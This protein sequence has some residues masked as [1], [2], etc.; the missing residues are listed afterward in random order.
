MPSDSG[1]TYDVIVELENG[2]VFAIETGLSKEEAEK[3]KATAMQLF[4]EVGVV[5]QPAPKDVKD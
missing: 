4:P 5:E 2:D 1:P 3:T